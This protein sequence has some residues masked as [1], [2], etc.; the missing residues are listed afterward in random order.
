MSKFLDNSGLVTF[1]KNCKLWFSS[2]I[3]V[4]KTSNTLTFSLYGS[5]E[6]SGQSQ[7]RLIDSASISLQTGS[8]SSISAWSAGTAPSLTVNSTSIPNVTDVGSATTA[9]VG[10]DGILVITQGA[11]P[12]LGTAI[13]VGSAS[14]WSAGT[15]P[16]LTY[17]DASVLSDISVVTS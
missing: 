7:D 12:T 17:S 5:Q 9:S 11:V 1:W 14:N 4:S 15:A 3:G 6:V 8:V 10:N 16:S 2:K 13:S